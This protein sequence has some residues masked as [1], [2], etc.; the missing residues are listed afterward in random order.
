MTDIVER[1][2]LYKPLDHTSTLINEAA[3]E[4]ESLRQRVAE[5]DF[6]YSEM[7]ETA[8]KY[9]AERTEARQQLAA[10]EKEIIK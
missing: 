7:N 1:L 6:L 10:C 9:L 8:R 5:L 2:R 4:I 3:D